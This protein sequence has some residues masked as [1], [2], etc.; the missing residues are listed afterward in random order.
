[1]GVSTSGDLHQFVEIDG[2]R[3]S[4]VIDP[5]TGLGITTGRQVTVITPEAN[6]VADALATAGCVLESDE[7]RRILETHHPLASA[8]VFE[9]VD[10]RTTIMLIGDPPVSV[11]EAP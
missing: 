11:P 6:G 7:F 3:Y 4:H 10:E 5:G 9:R 8:V 2:V 1:M